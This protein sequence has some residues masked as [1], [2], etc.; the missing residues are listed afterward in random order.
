M[1]PN[2]STVMFAIEGGMRLY[3]AGKQVYVDKTLA[4]PMPLPMPSSSSGGINHVSARRWFSGET[5]QSVVRKTQQNCST[6]GQDKPQGIG[7]GGTGRALH[8]RVS[9]V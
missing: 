8:R 3:A 4:R 5:G 1:S 2:V 9:T 7:K 6:P